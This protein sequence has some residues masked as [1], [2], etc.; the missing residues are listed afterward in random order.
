MCVVCC[1]RRTAMPKR[2]SYLQGS[3]RS[4][5]DGRRVDREPLEV[6][7]LT[8]LRMVTSEVQRLI[9]TGSLRMRST[10]CVQ[11]HALNCTRSTARAQLHALNC[12]RSTAR[13]QLHALNCTHSTACAQL[14]ALSSTARAQ[15]YALNC[16]R[17]TVCA[18]L[19][20]LNCMLQKAKLTQLHAV[21][22]FIE[23]P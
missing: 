10:A 14:H 13:A 20:A 9:C 12:T 3:I 21:T 23:Y 8:Q 19:H 11:L 1:R 17:S 16:M 4:C 15:M 6:A 18:Q 5:C 7:K 2:A 22:S